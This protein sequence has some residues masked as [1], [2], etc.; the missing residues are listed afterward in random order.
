MITHS[1]ML[2][3]NNCTHDLNLYLNGKFVKDDYCDVCLD[4]I[5]EL[6]SEQ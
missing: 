3:Y 6:E 5:S 1:S 4:S 2:R